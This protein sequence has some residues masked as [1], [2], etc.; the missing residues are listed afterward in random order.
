MR[1]ADSI[2]GTNAVP[3]WPPQFTSAK[4]GED[5]GN[6]DEDVDE[7]AEHSA[8][9]GSGQRVHEFRAGCARELRW[10]ATWSVKSGTDPFMP[11]WTFPALLY[12]FKLDPKNRRRA[13][14]TGS[15]GR[16]N[17]ALL[18]HSC[19]CNSLVN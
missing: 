16:C 12:R 13:G 3:V 1:F 11:L 15:D 17:V 10:R 2:P 4:P 8:D 5:D 18:L 14:H 19:G 7:A 6:D 9:Y